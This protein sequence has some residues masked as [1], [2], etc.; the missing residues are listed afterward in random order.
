[1]KSNSFRGYSKRIID[2]WK[3]IIYG[4]ELKNKQEKNNSSLRMVQSTYHDESILKLHMFELEKARL[5]RNLGIKEFSNNNWE[6]DES[7]LYKTIVNSEKYDRLL[8]KEYAE[9]YAEKPNLNKYPYFRDF[10]CTNFVSQALAA[11]G[12]KCLGKRISS[13][14]S[15]FCSTADYVNHKDSI[16]I[17]DTWKDARYF[18]LHWGN[19]KGVGLNRASTFKKT[20]K[21]DFIENFDKI[22]N[23]LEIGDLLQYGDPENNDYPYH[24]Q[25]I[26]DKGYNVCTNRNDLLVAQHSMNAKGISLFKYVSLLKDNRPIYIYKV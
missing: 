4:M 13:L 24:T 14:N 11:G 3:R 2:T 18:I 21:L 17:S 25:I 10:D 15:W 16:R 26:H 23:L 20:T 12:M 6:A 5:T 19:N 1:M 9:D 8:V 22:Y 7:F